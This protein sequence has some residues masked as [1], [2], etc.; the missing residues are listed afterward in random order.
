MNA[1]ETKKELDNDFSEAKAKVASLTDETKAEWARYPKQKLTLSIDKDII[2][3]AK[4]AGIN[5][6]AITEKVLGSLTMD[7]KGATH[8]DV[9][10]GYEELFLVI[11]EALKKY[12]ANVNVG[13][14][15][16]EEP[17]DEGYMVGDDVILTPDGLYAISFSHRWRTVQPEEVEKHGEWLPPFEIL[18]KFLKSLISAAEVNRKELKELNIALRFVKALSA[19]TGNSEE[20]S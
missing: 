6:S 17:D 19:G 13:V 4:D 9:K 10:K 18:E 5:I 15:Q 3:R 12:N 1:D 2:E 7:R 11:R 8:T 14:I 20:T 16:G